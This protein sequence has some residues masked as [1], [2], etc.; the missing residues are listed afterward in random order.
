[1]GDRR[2]PGGPVDVEAG[3]GPAHPFGLAG[4]ESHPDADRLSIRP[5]LGG[6][7]PLPGDRRGDRRPC[8]LEP[9]EERVALGA[10][11]LAVVGQP[12]PRAGWLGAAPAAPEA[13]GSELLPETGRA[14]DVGEQEGDGACRDA[15]RW[16][17]SGRRGASMV[18]HLGQVA[19]PPG[20][21]T[22]DG[23]RDAS[24]APP[25]WP[26]TPTTGER[27]RSSVRGSPPGRSAD[28]HR[29]STARRRT[30]P[31]PRRASGTP[32]RMTSTVP[33]TTM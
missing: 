29:G 19:Q 26:R 18:G 13:R 24:A 10:L 12:T 31:G 15:G 2:Y 9:D 33:L 32:S 23:E 17:S 14:L 1:M 8:A 7:R 11:L 3:E 22:Q 5:G 4:V 21:L 25:R 16:G 27:G 30:R 28:G 6:E 20:E